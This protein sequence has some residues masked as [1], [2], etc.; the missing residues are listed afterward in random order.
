MKT[1]LFLMLCSIATGSLA[2][3]LVLSGTPSKMIEIDQ[4]GGRSTH[5]EFPKTE[6]RI[7]KEGD[8]YFWASRGDI[9]LAVTSSGIYMTY[10][11]VDGSGYIRTVN[12]TARERFIQESPDSI[13]G[14]YTYVEHISQDMTSTIIYGR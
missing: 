10:I 1:L 5:S 11:A 7:T 9:P 8:H 6:L 2:Q 13:V 4:F 3:E 12:E 14:R